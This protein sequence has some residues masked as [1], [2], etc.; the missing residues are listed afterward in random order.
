MGRRT[1]SYFCRAKFIRYQDRKENAY[2]F[3]QLTYPEMYILE[4]GYYSFYH[5][6]LSHCDPRDYVRMDAEGAKDTCERNLA[7]LRRSS[8]AM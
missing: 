5:S 6:H 2:R 8:Q 1:L 3:P 4:G 7:K